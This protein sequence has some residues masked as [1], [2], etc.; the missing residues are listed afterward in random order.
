MEGCHWPFR[1]AATGGWPKL[2]KLLLEGRSARASDCI[3][4]LVDLA[5]P[6][7]EALKATG[8]L[9][10]RDDAGIPRRSVQAE[11]LEGVPSEVPGL[12]PGDPATEAAR[13]A[14]VSTV[15]EA[16]SATLADAIGIQAKHSADFMS[17]KACRRG[18]V[19]QTAAKTL[20]V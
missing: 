1:K 15:G 12:V 3:G 18:V 20:N 14:I 11:P 5:A 10:A 19:G 9:L 7:D 4:W 8:A 2:L 16:C 13:L 6:L 17:S